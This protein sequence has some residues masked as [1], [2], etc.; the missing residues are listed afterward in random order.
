MLPQPKKP[1]KVSATGQMKTPPLSA[2]LDY[3]VTHRNI[4]DADFSS[5]LIGGGTVVG[6]LRKTSG[7]EPWV[8]RPTLK[9]ATAWPMAIH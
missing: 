5:A 7:D 6:R 3:L 9:C 1:P 2:L 4:T 8:A